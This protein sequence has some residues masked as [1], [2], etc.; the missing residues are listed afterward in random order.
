M[1]GLVGAL[2]FAA[3]CAAHADTSV[4]VVAVVSG[5]T[6]F[7]SELS[8]ALAPAGM[9]TVTADA[10]APSLAEV[11]AASRSLADHL[12]ATATIWF[13]AGASGTTLVTY[14]RGVDRV[15]VR[16]LAFAMPLSTAQ[17]AEAA[18][19]ARTM[20]R[21]LRVTPDSA[22]PPPHVEEA[23]AL[24]AAAAVEMR[25]ARPRFA[26]E[27]GVGTRLRGPASN[28]A[29]S[30][31]AMLIWRPDALGVAIAGSYAPSASVTVPALSGTTGDD[32]A[33]ILARLPIA[34][35]HVTLAVIAGPALHVITVRGTVVDGDAVAI[36]RYDVAA[37]VGVNAGYTLD[38]SVDLGLEASADVLFQRQEYDFDASEVI[39]IP[40]VQVQTL[41]TLTL[42]VR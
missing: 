4:E 29:P 6:V 12:H 2:V 37:R 7:R 5:D 16:A 21:A 8:D 10:E 39:A 28:V 14:D 38:P 34:L 19:M 15:L 9:S 1:R 41:L 36:R 23:R 13:I 30:A 33:A 17:G 24:R 18:R 32:S 42:R 25:P 26:I 3:T 11:T 27:A 31:S 22:L 35:P 20:L 40:R